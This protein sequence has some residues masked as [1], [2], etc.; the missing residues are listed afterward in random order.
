MKV[1]RLR[2]MPLAVALLL[3][4]LLSSSASVAQESFIRK[5]VD[6]SRGRKTAL[7]DF[8]KLYDSF[9]RLSNGRQLN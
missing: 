8:A 5:L 3:G 4:L 1:L 2:A 9:D 7:G 6:Q